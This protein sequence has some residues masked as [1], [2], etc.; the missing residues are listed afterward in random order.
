MRGDMLRAGF[1]AGMAFLSVWALLAWLAR[2]DAAPLRPL[3][4]R[5]AYVGEQ[6]W[7]LLAEARRI[8]EESA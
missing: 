2:D 3:D 7:H 6:V 8:T 4:A 5:E 1:A